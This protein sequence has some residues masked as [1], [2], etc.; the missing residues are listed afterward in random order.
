MQKGNKADPLPHPAPAP[1]ASLLRDVRKNISCVGPRAGRYV[2]VPATTSEARTR[3]AS[4][5]QPIPSSALRIQDPFFHLKILHQ[6]KPLF[7]LL[8]RSR[9]NSCIQVTLS[10][11]EVR[12]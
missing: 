11:L 12:W 9:R 6:G 2:S 5:H 1:A 8:H 3:L 4:H 10:S 7:I